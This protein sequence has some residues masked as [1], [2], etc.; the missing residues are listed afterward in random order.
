M[1]KDINFMTSTNLDEL[2]EEHKKITH[3]Y[4]KYEFDSTGYTL[5]L[6]DIKRVLKENTK[7]RQALNE[8]SKVINEC[9]KLMSHEFY[10]EEQADNILQI[11]DKVRGNDT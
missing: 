1:N 10:W 3:P 9:K 4:K 7:L 6:C 2:L 5:L 11:I 8:I